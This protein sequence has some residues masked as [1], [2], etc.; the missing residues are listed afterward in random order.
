MDPF[1]KVQPGQQVRIPAEAY[2]SFIDAARFVRQ[3]HNGFQ[4]TGDI[5]RQTGIVKVR[6]DSGADRARFDVLGIDSPVITPTVNLQAFKNDVALVGVVPAQAVHSGRFVILLEPLAAGAIGRGFCAGVCPAR[7]QVDD[8]DQLYCDVE[9]GDPTRLR[10][11]YSGPA[12]ILWKETGT[13]LKWAVVRINDPASEKLCCYFARSYP[14]SHESYADTPILKVNLAV[15]ARAARYAFL[16]NGEVRI[17]GTGGLNVGAI[18]NA[19][20]NSVSG[21]DNITLAQIYH[22]EQP[23]QGGMFRLSHLTVGYGKASGAH[24]GVPICVGAGDLLSLRVFREAGTDPMKTIAGQ[25]GLNIC[26]CPNFVPLRD[27]VF[28]LDSSNDNVDFYSHADHAAFQGGK[29]WTWSFVTRGDDGLWDGIGGSSQQLVD[30]ANVQKAPY[31]AFSIRFDRDEHRI[32]AWVNFDD[33]SKLVVTSEDPFKPPGQSEI[34]LE[35][36]ILFTVVVS[37]NES[38]GTLNIWMRKLSGCEPTVYKFS[39]T[40]VGKTSK[41]GSG[42]PLR[43]MRGDLGAVME[44]G[45][46]HLFNADLIAADEPT[47]LRLLKGR[48][49]DNHANLVGAW[50]LEDQTGTAGFGGLNLTPN[51]TIEAGGPAWVSP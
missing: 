20:R 19:M 39:G 30:K 11:G 31:G 9:D 12:R 51:G 46:L 5:F 33:G 28:Y 43:V 50:K 4:Q 18:V 42:I 2:N 49:I 29:S 25:S 16:E 8:I 41:S 3:R 13:G 32:H 36:N 26:P 17:L 15:E 45:R 35:E 24:P 14:Y 6:N 40:S 38:T 7:V 44:M 23:I 10:A 34:N 21:G 37:W 47:V 27:P 48:F 22:N 1:K